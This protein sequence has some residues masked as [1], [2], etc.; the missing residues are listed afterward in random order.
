MKVD[1]G[2]EGLTK[3]WQRDF[4]KETECIYC[5]GISRIGFVAHERLN[6]DPVEEKIVASLH[7]NNGKGDYWLHDSCAVSVYFCKDCLK[8]TALFNQA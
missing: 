2:E 3:T 1:I 7:E 8:P 6:K 4:P 5:K